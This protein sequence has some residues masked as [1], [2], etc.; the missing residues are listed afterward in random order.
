MYNITSVSFGIELANDG[1]GTGQPV[2]VRLYANNGGAFPGGSRTQIASTNVTVM[3]QAQTIFDVPLFASVPAGTSEL[4]ME[5]FTPSGQ[6]AGNSFFIGSN[7]APETGPSYISAD[8][9]GTP[10]PTTT[11]AVGFP[12][13]HIIFNVHGSCP[14]SGSGQSVEHLNAP[15]SRTGRQRDDWG[16]HHSRER[17]QDSGAAGDRAIAH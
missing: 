5:V 1:D 15:A 2:T 4:V 7:T 11:A 13:M 10:T 9:C 17:I 3:D 6:D 16:I 12:D 14:H 8:E